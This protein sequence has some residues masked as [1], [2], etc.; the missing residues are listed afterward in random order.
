[1]TISIC[2]RDMRRMHRPLRRL[3]PLAGHLPGGVSGQRA[4]PGLGAGEREEEPRSVGSVSSLCSA[5]THWDWDSG[6]G[7]NM[8]LDYPRQ[9][10][11]TSH[12]STVASRWRAAPLASFLESRALAGRPRQHPVNHFPPSISIHPSVITHPPSRPINTPPS[13]H[14]PTSFPP[15]AVCPN[16]LAPAV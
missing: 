15:A 13:T 7:P 14:D 5:A 16:C 1:M 6:T 2:A 9:L 3:V 11:R 10:P 8:D 4:R 12:Y